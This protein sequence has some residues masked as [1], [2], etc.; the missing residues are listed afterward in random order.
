MANILL[1]GSVGVAGSASILGNFNVVFS[2][3]ANHTMSPTEFSNKFLEVTSS[4]SLT[5]T[6]NLVAPLNQG[7]EYVVQNLTAGGHSIQI[8]GPTGTG[9]VIANGTTP[10]S[11]VCDG[12][13]YLQSSG[14]G[15]GGGSP[16]GPAGGDLAGSYP[17]PTVT[18]LNGQ[19]TNFGAPVTASSPTPGQ[20]LE[21]VGGAWNA[22]TL[23]ASGVAW[24]QDLGMSSPNGTAGSTDASQIVTAISGAH[25]AG[26]SFPGRVDWNGN[27]LFINSVPARLFQD[28]NIH[29]QPPTGVGTVGSD[30][31]SIILTSQ[32]G[33]VGGV[34]HAS[35]KGG[36][37][38]LFA[39]NGTSGSGS[40]GSNG[41]GIQI[42]S[43]A[44]A[45]PGVDGDI[46]ITLPGATQRILIT[47]TAGAGSNGV[48]VQSIDNLILTNTESSGPA[49][50]LEISNTYDGY[51]SFLKMQDNFIYLNS[52]VQN[53]EYPFVTLQ[54]N[55]NTQFQVAGPPYPSGVYPLDG[56]LSVVTGQTQIAS[57]VVTIRTLHGNGTGLVGTD[58]NGILSFVPLSGLSTTWAN[59]L[60]GST[61]TSQFVAAISGN[62]GAGGTIP[63]NALTLQFN[64]VQNNPNVNQAALVSTSS[65]SGASG[66]TLTIQAQAGQAATGASH[67]GG[68]GGE[69][70][71]KG[72]AG[73]TSG[74]ATAGTAGQILITDQPGANYI[75]ILPSLGTTT[76]QAGASGVQNQLTLSNAG[77]TCNTGVTFQSVVVQTNSYTV[78]SGT[79]NGFLDYYVMCD[80]AGAGGAI[81]LTLPL[82]TNGRT[83]IIKDIGGL[84]GTRNITITPV[85]S[86]D[87]AATYTITVNYG[88][89]V[90]AGVKDTFDGF[91]EQW[92]VVGEYNGAII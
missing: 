27:D 74:S 5:A 92:F 58:N 81:A 55:G 52:A 46:A 44:G 75:Q 78:D 54:T 14:G 70:L 79:L 7:Q 60:V 25:G 41:G 57:Q 40:I 36:N 11:V 62:A 43:G 12:T 51:A 64:N 37:I 39:G 38:E 10:V 71:L 2:A 87:G 42:V 45:S 59:D 82:A 86:I 9:I 19:P 18:K 33:Q 49:P 8:I 30:G 26:S 47:N 61:G 91:S 77:F 76:I 6:R 21:F 48:T 17:N 67:N 80:T 68:Q 34:G 65:G 31:Y 83:I 1:S 90:L 73:G 56:Y 20:V 88:C 24:N 53:G 63:I 22:V 84:A 4:T 13:N 3:D 89:I 23:S 28:F 69:L 50:L 15:G 32:I 35:G 29:F 72:G 16:T 85:S 66:K